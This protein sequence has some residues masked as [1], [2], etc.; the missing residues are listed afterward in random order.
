MFSSECQKHN[1]DRPPGCG[2]RGPCVRGRKEGRT[3]KCY[4]GVVE[5]I[6][7]LKFESLAINK[8]A[9]VGCAA[10]SYFAKKDEGVVS[11]GG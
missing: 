2:A 3:I 8:V 10:Q 7:K 11:R 4:I 5:P 9:L 1:F 6:L